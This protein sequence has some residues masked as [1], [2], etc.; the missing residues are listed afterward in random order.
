MWIS[1]RHPNPP[2]PAA[3][4]TDN[5]RRLATLARGNDAELRVTL[6]QYQ[7]RPYCAFRV[8]ERGTDGHL[9]PARNK[10]LS[11]RISE[12]ADVI[13]ALRNCEQL[14]DQAEQERTEAPRPATPHQ[15]HQDARQRADGHAT[16]PRQG[17]G[18]QPVY[19]EQRRRPEGRT[20]TDRERGILAERTT[21]GE[22]DEFGSG[23]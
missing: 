1:D 14:V 19:R 15:G 11:V 18:D 2:K 5:G 13:A 23:S 17:E 22:F 9:W 7:G 6:A 16:A 10:G 4:P 8:W 21:E 12:L 3:P 20:M